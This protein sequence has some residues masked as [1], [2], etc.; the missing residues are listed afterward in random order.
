M[1]QPDRDSNYM[2][3]TFGTTSLITD[4]VPEKNNVLTLDCIIENLREIASVSSEEIRQKFE[5]SL[6]NLPEEKVYTVLAESSFES[7]YRCQA[8]AI[9][10]LLEKLQ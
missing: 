4:Y 6:E 7:G 8:K 10:T 2:R 1:S 9:L 5:K 3:E